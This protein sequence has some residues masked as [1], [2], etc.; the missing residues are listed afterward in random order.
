MNPSART[1]DPNGTTKL[2]NFRLAIYPDRLVESANVNL[3][4]KIGRFGLSV[5]VGGSVVR[6]GSWCEDSLASIETNASEPLPELHCLHAPTPILQNT[7]STRSAGTAG[8][9]PADSS[10][11]H[12]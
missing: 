6:V 8:S 1:I 2:T 11:Q 3:R 7:Y 9:W 12:R 10:L 5:R 4:S